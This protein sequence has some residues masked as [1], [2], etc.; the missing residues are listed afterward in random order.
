MRSDTIAIV[1][2]GGGL[3]ILATLLFKRKSVPHAGYIQP[4]Q[5][6]PTISVPSVAPVTGMNQ[7]VPPS[8]FVSP[9]SRPEIL[10]SPKSYK[11][12]PGDNYFAVAL[13]FGVPSKD[14]VT[15]NAASGKDFNVVF[16]APGSLIKL[17]ANILDTGPKQGALGSV[18]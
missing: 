9:T 8:A 3:A 18:Q 14:L 13:R 6:A 10:L 4:S 5:M 2:A 7:V 17:P 12:A 1:A 11:I 15:I 16:R